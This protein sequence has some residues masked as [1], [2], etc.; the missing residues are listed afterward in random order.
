M[1]IYRKAVS[2]RENYLIEA[3]IA[4]GNR[5]ALM[6][7]A[8]YETRAHIRNVLVRS[9]RDFNLDVVRAQ[10]RAGEA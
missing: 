10:K 1:S 6:R 4:R 3:A 2:A 8:R 5:L 9:A 7:C